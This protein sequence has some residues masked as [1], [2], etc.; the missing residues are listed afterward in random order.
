M[1]A[2]YVYRRSLWWT[3]AKICA[4]VCALYLVLAA[5]EWAFESAPYLVLGSLTVA[6]GAVAAR[7]IR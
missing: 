5:V 2:R 7:V 6:A 3:F 4:A 1:V